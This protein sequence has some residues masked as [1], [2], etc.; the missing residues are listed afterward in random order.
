MDCAIQAWVIEQCG[1]TLSSI[2]L[3]CID[4][5]FVYQGNDGYDGLFVR[6][7]ITDQVREIMGDVANWSNELATMLKGAC[8]ETNVGKQCHNPYEC[9]Y[10]DYCTR[11]ESSYPVR[12]LPRAGMVPHELKYEGIE[13]IR[14]IPADRLKNN[15]HEWVRRV[16]VSGMPELKPEATAMIQ[17]LGY[18]RYYIDFESIQFAIPIWKGTRPFQ[19]LPFQWSC[20]VEH[21]TGQIGHCDYLATD[22]NPPMREFAETLIHAL[23]VTGP[24]LVYSSFEKSR[25]K[26]LADMY[27]DLADALGRIIERLVDLLP[28]VRQHYYHPEMKGSWSV[29]SVL[30][31]VAPELD[32]KALDEVRDGSMAQMAYLEMIN[33]VT[34]PTRKAYLIERLKAYCEMDTLAMVKIAHFIEV[35]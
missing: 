24:V 22:S 25:L 13:D 12:V 15:N 7:D 21:S 26:E 23:G 19:Q 4:S 6:H 18:P 20:H 8:P 16:T 32:Y 3:M 14:D 28:I 17:A 33:S 31:T 27:P 1:Y 11:D 30:P 10:F 2:E 34:E 29:K 35:R 9:G 5:G